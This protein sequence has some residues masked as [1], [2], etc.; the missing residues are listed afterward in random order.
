MSGHNPKLR[1]GLSLSEAK[2]N[3]V[4]SN[5]PPLPII[6]W[7]K[8][9]QSAPT[10]PATPSGSLPKADA[11]VITWADAEWA[12]MEH[13][14]C[15]SN[16]TMPYTKRT[17]GTWSGWEKW[18]KNLPSGA[19]SNWNYWGYYRLIQISARNVLLF[20]SNTHLDWP[21]AKY[22]QDMIA[23]LA[24]DVKPR[25][26]LSIGTAGGA[27]PTDHIGTV[28]IASA[29]TLYESGQPSGSWPVY[30]NSWN[31]PGA[32]L[33]NPG[34][35]SLLFSIPTTAADL[36]SLCTQFNKFYN[37]N[38]TLAQLNPGNLNMGDT[39]PQIDNQT[40][41]AVSLLTTPTFVVGSIA[42]T[43]QAYTCIE[44][45]DAVIGEACKTAGVSF[46]FVRN[47]SDPVQNS[48]LPVKAGGNWGSVIYDAYGLYTSYN[49][50]LA[51]WAV[52]AP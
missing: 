36:Q 30:S 49:G 35:K 6:D 38:D 20:K 5:T 21:G 51:A 50:A 32:I 48:A 52:L 39:S 34:F 26:I 43:Y 22:L 15:A 37:T 33:A 24:A 25:L 46:G 2:L 23:M 9:G 1:L 16:A 8:V 42:G 45:D 13:V 3:P 12:A 29:G 27:K 17:E 14:F 31:A 19:A 7:T 47:I 10:L 11:V 44:M 18:A 40:G 41:G 28:R 4:I